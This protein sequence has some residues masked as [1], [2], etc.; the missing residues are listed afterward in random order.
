MKTLEIKTADLK[1]LRKEM[2]KELQAKRYEHTLSVAYTAAALASVYDEDSG[3]ALIAGMLHDC[4]KCLSAKKLISICEKNDLPVSEM[5]L[6]NP[7]ALL[8]AKV[9]SFLAKEKY[10][11]E[12]EDVLNAIRFHTTGRPC[13]STLEKILYIADYIEP[14]RK[15]ASNLLQIRRMAF[16]DLDKTLFKILEDTLSYLHSVSGHLDENVQKIGPVDPITQETYL[17]YK[18]SFR[19][20][21]DI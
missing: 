19:K 14:G 11:I 12:D 6:Q 20:G 1:K 2:E 18:N 5:E 3:K 7:T 16:Q 15:H 8:H 4:A 10:G 13:M 9:G 21:Q 17:Y